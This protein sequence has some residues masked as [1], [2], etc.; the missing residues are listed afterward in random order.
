M[1][2]II[3]AIMV[4]ALAL[5]TGL[6]ASATEMLDRDYIKTEIWDDMWNGKGDNG[7][8]FPEASYKHHLLDKWLDENYGSDEV[9]HDR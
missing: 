3:T 7:I 9:D 5:G 2:N 1:K 4:T 6:T 8:D